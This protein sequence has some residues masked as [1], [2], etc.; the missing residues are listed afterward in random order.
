MTSLIKWN[1]V[2]YCKVCTFFHWPSKI[3]LSQCVIVWDQVKAKFVIRMNGRHVYLPIEDQFFGISARNENNSSCYWSMLPLKSAGV[4]CCTVT[5]L[6]SKQSNKLASNTIYK[7]EHSFSEII[8]L[9]SQLGSILN[10]EKKVVFF[11]RKFQRK[12]RHWE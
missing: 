2:L 10:H 6:V 11:L 5:A 9:T 8:T 7:K 12:I 4:R 3:T 1:I